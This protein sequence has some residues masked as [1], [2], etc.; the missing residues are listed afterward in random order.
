MKNAIIL[1]GMPSKR[2]YYDPNVL[3]MS[4]LHWIPW[5]QSQ[6]IKHDIMAATPEMP[7][8]YAPDWKAW[9]REVERF[10]VGP[11][12]LLVG[13]SCG[14]GFWVRYLSERKDLRVGKVVLVAPWTDPDRDHTKGFFEFEID[15]E[16]AA[17]TEGVT[18]FH[19][20]NDAGNIHKTV[21]SL[22]ESIRDI[23]YREFDNYGHFTQKS[24]GTQE[25][26]ELLQELL[27]DN[28]A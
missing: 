8:A 23:G 19:S 15:S 7:H 13:H 22:R 14:G 11:E 26:P 27:G 5:L 4:N 20:A 16:L 25:F 18:V 1:H 9:V 28:Q 17:R 3:S 21:A 6:L 10:E 24:M 12:T 2:E